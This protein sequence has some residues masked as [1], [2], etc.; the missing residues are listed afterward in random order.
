MCIRDRAWGVRV[1]DVAST[2]AALAVTAAFEA[3]AR[4]A[5]SVGAG[6]EA[7]PT[8]DRITLTGLEVFA[9]SLIHI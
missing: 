5:T 3:G 1:H 9:L 7:Q 6:F 2:A 4:T 8:R